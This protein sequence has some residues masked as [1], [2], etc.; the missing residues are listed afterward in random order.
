ML[1]KILN[2]QVINGMGLA[3]GILAISN[4]VSRLLALVRDRILAN[5]FGAG[6]EL[7]I[8]FT[9]FLL[10]DLVFGILIMGGIS[11][12]FLPLF[13]EYFKKSQKEGWLFVNNILNCFLI[14]LIFICLILVILTPFLVEFIAPGFEPE[15]KELLISL[16]RIM[17]LSP[18]FFSLS[19]IF[20]GIAHYFNRFLLY[21]IAPILYNLSIIFG[22]LFLVPIFG[23]VG[24]AYGVVLGAF[25]HWLIQIPAAYNSG[26][27]YSLIYN[28]KDLGLIK[29]FKLMLPR[30]IGLAAF[31]LNLIIVTAIASTLTIGS[32]TVFNF[33]NNLSHFPIGLIGASFALV[34]FP[35]LARAWANGQQ[36]EFL[37]KFS[38]V[39]RQVLFFIIP[40]SFLIFLLRE[41]IVRLIL[42]TGEFG[43]WETQLTAAALG[44]FSF[45]IFALA[46]IPFLSKVFFSFQNTRTPVKIGLYSVILNIS[47]AFLFVW[48]LTFPNFFQN[49]II[50]FLNLGEIK[51]IEVIGLVL[52]LTVSAI[53]QFFLL[54]FSL[55]KEI[56]LINFREIKQSFKKILLATIFMS[57]FTYL[58]LYLIGG[59]VDVRTFEGVFIQTVSTTLI[60]I[61]IYILI[62][63]FLK[64]PE[65]KI[66]KNLIFKK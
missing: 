56:S 62:T 1:D 5:Q 17:F 15:Q 11:A 40:I 47:L 55:K 38:L 14:L 10:P 4:L 61:S 35:V 31:H 6:K 26:F 24:L 50:N 16:T 22:I 3:V 54:V 29:A 60:G 13:S 51:N 36:D 41:Q 19:S 18:I 30:T 32:I 28:F 7:D 49:L 42:S 33:A 9:A 12:V 53:F 48:F 2:H 59:V 21:A 45:A 23:L 66:I 20:S 44:L 34:S 58:T 52:A 64:S 39:F 65:I 57:I 43:W 46:L 25:F 63:Y 37:Q 8:Y 27:R